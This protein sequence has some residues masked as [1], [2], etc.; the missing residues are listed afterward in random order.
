MGLTFNSR[1]LSRDEKVCE[2]IVKLI[3][4]PLY[5]SD[6]SEPL[7]EKYKKNITIVSGRDYLNQV[8]DDE[9]IFYETGDITDY[10]NRIT[11]IILYRWNRD[12]PVD[13]TLQINFDYYQLV[14]SVDFTGKSH[15]ITREKWIRK[16]E[17]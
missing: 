13:E 2:D 1:R 8:S 3:S 12:Y 16:K 10:Q 6:Y 7:F 9:Y 17:S 11:E 5:L 14:E 4:G 15:Q